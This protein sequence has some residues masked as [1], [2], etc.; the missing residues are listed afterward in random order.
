MGASEGNTEP[1]SVYDFTVKDIKGQDVALSKYRGHVVLIVNLA[2]QCG[3]TESN[4]KQLAELHEK[5]AANDPPLSILGFPC[6]EFG[7]QE[8]GTNEEIENFARTQYNVKFDLF[9]KINV[10]GEDADPLWKYLKSKQGGTLTDGIK[11]NFTKFLINR[12][13][14][15]VGRY[16]STTEPRR[17]EG[18]IQKL[19][20]GASRL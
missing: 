10:N 1:S 11:W 6:N 4:Y 9:A 8:P 3:F 12:D 16:G 5:Y 18:D 14:I 13:G 17:I 7:S 15:P 2:S 19:L 20:A